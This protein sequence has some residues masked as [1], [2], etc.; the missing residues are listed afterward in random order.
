MSAWQHNFVNE[1]KLRQQAAARKA[2]D[3]LR[4]GLLIVSAISLF[5]LLF[6]V[7]CVK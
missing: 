4:S 7:N 6:L 5:L 3:S 2:D 1:E